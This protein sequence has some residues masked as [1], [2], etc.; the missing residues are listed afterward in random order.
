MNRNTCKKHEY[1]GKDD[2]GPTYIEV[3]MTEQK[4]YYYVDG[5]LKIETEVVT[6]INEPWTWNTVRNQ[7]C[8]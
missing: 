2:I 1:Q 4:M 6:G 8:L 3:D 5:V 7:L